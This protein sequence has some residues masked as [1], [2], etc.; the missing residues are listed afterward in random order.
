MSKE[1]YHEGHA[2]NNTHTHTSKN[3]KPA[4]TNKQNKKLNKSSGCPVLSGESYWWVRMPPVFGTLTVY[5]TSQLGG[6]RM[7][8][9]P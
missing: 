4:S 2:S 6:K 3:M 7:E 8:D 9:A 1:N 5:V